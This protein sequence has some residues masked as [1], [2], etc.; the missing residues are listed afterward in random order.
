[1]MEHLPPDTTSFTLV[2]SENGH[3]G[4]LLEQDQIG[5]AITRFLDSL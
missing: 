3:D 5:D 4:F 1:M 2:V